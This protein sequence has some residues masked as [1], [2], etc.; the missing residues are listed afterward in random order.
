MFPRNRRK[1]SV[2]VAQ[3][4][5]PVRTEVRE[6]SRGWVMRALQAGVGWVLFQV[7]GGLLEGLGSLRSIL[8][9]LW[10]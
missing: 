3:W 5:G 2:A 1:V 8:K 9:A 7:K 6:S 4:T 10:S